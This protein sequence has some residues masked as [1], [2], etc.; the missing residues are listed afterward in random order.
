LGGAY[1]NGYGSPTILDI[2]ADLYPSIGASSAIA[3]N[4]ST[5]G[6]FSVSFPRY[7]SLSSSPISGGAK[8][9]V[10]PAFRMI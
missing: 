5:A 7:S 4:L 8:C 6:S 2:H 3:L 1:A 9:V 10:L